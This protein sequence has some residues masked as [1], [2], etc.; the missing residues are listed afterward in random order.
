[1]R[2]ILIGIGI[3]ILIKMIWLLFVMYA[4]G[5]GYN[6]K[7]KK[8]DDEISKAI[9][10]KMGK[11]VLYDGKEIFGDKIYYTYLVK[12]EQFENKTIFSDIA[13]IINE[14]LEEK[15]IKQEFG[16]RKDEKIV[17]ILAAVISGGDEWIYTVSNYS[18]DTGK[19]YDKLQVLTLYGS[20]HADASDSSVLNNCATYFGFEDI[21][22]LTISEK[23]E[24]NAKEEGVDWYEVWPN[25]E[26]FE[27]YIRQ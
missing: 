5:G 27:V 16:S 10:E 9:Y 23:I 6:P 1:M 11:T 22:S 2:K 15:S 14:N 12:R 24:K 17:L 18:E 25:L 3:T 26:H 19:V 21:R 20:R 8:A 13:G 4:I 7:N